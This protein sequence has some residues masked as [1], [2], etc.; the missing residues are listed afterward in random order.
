MKQLAKQKKH[1]PK[2]LYPLIKSSYGFAITDKS[3][4]IYF[5]DVIVGETT[6]DGK[7]MY[8]LLNEIKDTYVMDLPNNPTKESG[9]KLWKNEVK[10]FKEK[11]ED[12]FKVK[13]TKKS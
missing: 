3:P 9:Q 5:S 6:C 1:L 11:L 7:K 2:N 13:I 12:K 4:Y 8:E 10:L